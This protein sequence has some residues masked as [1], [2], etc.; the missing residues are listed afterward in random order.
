[1]ETRVHSY[2]YILCLEKTEINSVPVSTSHVQE[3]QKSVRRKGPLVSHKQ[4]TN[5]AC[6]LLPSSVMPPANQLPDE[7][8]QRNLDLTSTCSSAFVAGGPPLWCAP[9]AGSRTTPADNLAKNKP[10]L[11][12]IISEQLSLGLSRSLVQTGDC[13]LSQQESHTTSVKSCFNQGRTTVSANI[14]V[15]SVIVI[16]MLLQGVLPCEPKEKQFTRSLD[17]LGS[18]PRLEL[19]SLPGPVSKQGKRNSEIQQISVAK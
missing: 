10:G 6:G 17:A 9:D 7:P 15:K 4:A 18:S 11:V 5:T 16:A 2:I 19:R 13:L 3:A 12:L 8:Y 1:M 14:H